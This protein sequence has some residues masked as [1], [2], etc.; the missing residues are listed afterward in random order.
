MLERKQLTSNK[1]HQKVNSMLVSSYIFWSHTY[2]N[3][4]VTISVKGVIYN[5]PLQISIFIF[6]ADV[7]CN[8]TQKLIILTN[9]YYNGFPT[10][11]LN[12]AIDKW[13][14]VTCLECL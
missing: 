1:S 2:L 5:G 8:Y 13:T 11:E 4:G 10:H 9:F 14:S 12:Y 7:K 6:F 3:V